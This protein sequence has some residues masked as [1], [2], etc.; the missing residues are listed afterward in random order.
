MLESFSSETEELCAINQDLRTYI[1]SFHKESE[2]H[3][4][5][6][7]QSTAHF[8]NFSNITVD[9]DIITPQKKQIGERKISRK[10][11]RK[12]VISLST[13]VGKVRVQLRAK[14]LNQ[15][16]EI[17]LNKLQANKRKSQ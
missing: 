11:F 5:Y 17:K 7:E 3:A 13:K 1:D 9:S 2:G 8:N 15:I 16:R 14:Q 6:T 4:V 12:I 10:I